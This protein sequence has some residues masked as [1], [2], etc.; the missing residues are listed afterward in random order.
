MIPETQHSTKHTAKTSVSMKDFIVIVWYQQ[1]YMP[2]IDAI[3]GQLN[4]RFTNDVFALAKSVEAV[5][6]CD[7]KGIEPLIKQYGA[8]LNLNAKV[9]E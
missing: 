1:L 5:F 4:M 8:L 9:L 2:V 7:S 3:M 6:T